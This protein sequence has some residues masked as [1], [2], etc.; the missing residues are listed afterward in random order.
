MDSE[1]EGGEEGQTCCDVV[2][3]SLELAVQFFGQSDPQ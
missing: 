2:N 1:W 3:C